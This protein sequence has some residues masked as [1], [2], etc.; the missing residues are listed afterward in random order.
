MADP[1]RSEFERPLPS[2]TWERPASELARAL[3]GVQL[4]HRTPGGIRVVRIVETEAYGWSDPASHAFLGPTVRNRS[5]YGPPGTLYLYPIHQVLCA[6]VVGRPGEAALLRAGEPVGARL[7]SP[8]GPGRLS[9]ALAL[10]RE[11]DGSNLETSEVR[12]LR[13]TSQ[14]F[15]IET[16]VRVGISRA[17]ARPLRFAIAGNAWVS[18]PRLRLGDAER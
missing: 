14:K 18:R 4:A 6:N 9:R 15:V 10:H 12:L 2:A 11:L 5:M 16:G 3:L 7:S 17:R 8:S 13:G 1:L